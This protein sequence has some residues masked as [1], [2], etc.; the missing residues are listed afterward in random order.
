[1]TNNRNSGDNTDVRNPDGTFARG[2][3]GKPHG[4]RHK[5]TRAVQDLL[6]GSV[7]RL[8]EAAIDAALNGD[9]GAM[10]LCLERICPAQKDAPVEFDIPRMNNAADAAKAA[11]AIVEAVAQGTLTPAEGSHVMGLVD[12]Y[13]RTLEA[14]EIEQRLTALE[15][16]N[17]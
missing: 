1:M 9:T 14:T 15:N 2:N 12:S 16:Q 3:P 11:G 7:G 8:T 4:S 13:R 10:R 6:Q 5:A 17:A